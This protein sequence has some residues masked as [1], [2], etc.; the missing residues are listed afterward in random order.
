MFT[1]DCLG[2]KRYADYEKYCS[3][4]EGHTTWGRLE[5]SDCDFVA[6]QASPGYDASYQKGVP[7]PSLAFSVTLL[8]Y[9]DH[10]KAYWK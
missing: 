10:K 7:R 5:I 8:G 3:N 6:Y 4:Y 1:Q 9:E 2:W